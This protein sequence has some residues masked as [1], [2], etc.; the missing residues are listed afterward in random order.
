MVL[1]PLSYLE[2]AQDGI[3]F[4]WFFYAWS[5][6]NVFVSI[7]AFWI[8]PLIWIASTWAGTPASIFFLEWNY[9]YVLELV[10]G[11]AQLALHLFYYWDLKNW[12]Y[13]DVIPRKALKYCIR[14]PEEC[15][16]PIKYSDL[17]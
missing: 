16:L 8:G 7:S 2:G 5:L 1:W 11:L 10:F 3:D 9:V 4:A 15:T 13:G 6:V 14:R 17:K 12:Y